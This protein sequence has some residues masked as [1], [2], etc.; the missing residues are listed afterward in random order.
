VGQWRSC[1]TDGDHEL[2]DKRDED[3]N[4]NDA[5]PDTGEHRASVAV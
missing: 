2:D 5:V 4:S 3:Q 1:G